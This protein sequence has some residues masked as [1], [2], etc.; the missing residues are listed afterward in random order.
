MKDNF[1]TQSDKYRKF[2]PGYPAELFEF[3][4]SITRQKEVAWDCGTGN[5]QVA[6]ELAKYFKKV[7]AT[8]ISE[9]QLK[10]AVKAS[11]IFYEVAPAEKTSFPPDFFNLITVAQAIHWF[12]FDLFYK[13]VKRTIKPDGILAVIGYGLFKSE[14]KLDLVMETFYN[15]VI[16]PYWDK[17]RRYIDEN[18]ETIPF[19]FEEIR[20]P[21]FENIFKWRFEQLI[22]FLE[23]WSAV[24]HYIEKNGNNPLD[25]VYTDLKNAWGAGELKEI[26]FPILLRVGTVKYIE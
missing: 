1:S 26:R 10:A 3:L 18:Y 14:N 24:K 12:N 21:K 4:L 25:L 11:N 15:Q 5:G 13:E 19:P 16:G 20:A 23:T 9:S 22:G 6:M 7:Y 17:E 2:R 8:D